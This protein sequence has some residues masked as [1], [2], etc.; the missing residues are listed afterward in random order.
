LNPQNDGFVRNIARALF[1]VPRQAYFGLMIF[2]FLPNWYGYR[3]DRAFE[4]PLPSNNKFM[5]PLHPAKKCRI[6]HLG[7]LTGF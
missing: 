5:G 2:P 6:R 1:A 4:M 3:P 7:A